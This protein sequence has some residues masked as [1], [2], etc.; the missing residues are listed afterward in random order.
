M[1]AWRDLVRKLGIRVPWQ[2]HNAMDYLEARGQRF[3]VD[4]GTQNAV[5]KARQD[6]RD[7]RRKRAKR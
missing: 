5:E 2:K 1:S 3:C 7:R 4:F 6:W